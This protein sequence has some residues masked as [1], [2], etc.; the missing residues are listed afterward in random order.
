[1]LRRLAAWLQNRHAAAR[2]GDIYSQHKDELVIEFEN[3]CL[4]TGCNTPLTYAVPV[5]NFSRAGRNV[6][7]LFGALQGLRLLRAEAVEWERSLLLHF[8]QDYSLALKLHGI[9]AN[10][11][12]LKAGECVEIF[13]QEREKDRDWRP[14]PGAYDEAAA[15]ALAQL[16]PESEEATAQAL[17]RV[18]P[19]FDRFFAARAW[20]HVQGG[21]SLRQAFDESCREALEGPIYLFPDGGRMRLLLFPPPG[22]RLVRV[23]EDEGEALENFLY[24]NF[25]LEDYAAAW[26]A[27]RQQCE[28][29]LDKLNNVFDSYQESILHL[30]TERNPE[31]IGHLIMAQLHLIQ[32]GDKQVELEDFYHEQPLVVRLDPR[33]NA[34]ENAARYYEKSKERKAKAQHLRSQLAEL[35]QKQAEAQARWD[36]FAAIPAPENL[37]FG[38]AGFD[39]PAV[40]NWKKQLRSFQQPAR[41][42]KSAS[43]PYRAYRLD[44]YDIW[45]GSNAKNNDQLTFKHAKRDD[46][47]LHAKDVTGS[48]VI[49]R[50]KP[51][52]NPP[53]AV[54]EYAAGLA[55]WYSK[56]RNEPLAPVSYTERRY[57]RKRKGDPPGA[58]VVEREEVIL[59]EPQKG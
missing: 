25:L 47:W 32:P 44:G 6:A 33:R 13:K 26:R 10:V 11:L 5:Q 19:V 53:P 7:S 52:Q 27:A 22:G 14:Q 34:L 29:P 2:I 55:A 20:Q 9:Q 12:L 46:I 36:A 51:G 28:K 4:L 15:D 40:R 18:S 41:E 35:A 50:R 38:A 17:R 49:I 23:F 56:R 45:V 16:A 24:D 57:L 43:L 21:Q 42:A 3:G 39:G 58:V 1:M 30:E 8:E 54:L 48:H 59:V 37:P 31:E